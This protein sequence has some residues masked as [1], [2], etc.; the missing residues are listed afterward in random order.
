MPPGCCAELLTLCSA[1]IELSLVLIL[2]VWFGFMG[3][4][5]SAEDFTDFHVNSHVAFIKTKLFCF[6]SL[7]CL[8]GRERG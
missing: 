6:A 8:G 3:A 4:V 2:I 7:I 5:L 1:E